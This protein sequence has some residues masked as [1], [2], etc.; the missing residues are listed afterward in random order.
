M[1]APAAPSAEAFPAGKWALTLA[2]DDTRPAWIP[3]GGRTLSLG[4]VGIGY[5]VIDRLQIMAEVP[6]YYVSL[7]WP[8]HRRGGA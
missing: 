4:F 5:T 1:S 7:K 6:G 2:G 8:E 3:G